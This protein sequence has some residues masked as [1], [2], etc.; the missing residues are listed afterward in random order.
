MKIIG[1][2]GSSGAG[3]T[4]LSKI[5]NEQDDVK[6]IDADKVVKEMSVPGAEYLDAIKENFGE[7]IFLADGNLNRKALASKI[8]SD[9]SSREKLNS[10]TFKYIVNEILERI[11]KIKDSNIKIV[12]IDA[13]LLFE[14]GLDKCCDY[15]IALIADEELKIRR[16][17]KRDNIDEKTAKSRLN[18]Q[19][20]DSFY[21]KR[22]DFIIKNSENC[23]LK[24]EVEKL[25]NK[26]EI[27]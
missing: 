26:I 6:V 2:T 7:D 13:P 27:M 9:N 10:L 8:Y 25:L 12:I 21:I 24:S 19:N 22:A 3:K 4:T 17:C 16:I 14:S 20:E 15:V 23:D 18:I 11:D 1:I 5:L